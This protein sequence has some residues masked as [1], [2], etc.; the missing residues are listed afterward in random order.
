MIARSTSRCNPY[1]SSGDTSSQEKTRSLFMA[2]T[3]TS[4]ALHG[5]KGEALSDRK[6]GTAG[7]RIEWLRMM[8]MEQVNPKK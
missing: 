5:T 8:M 6:I 1:Q 7:T 4:R 3:N 2:G